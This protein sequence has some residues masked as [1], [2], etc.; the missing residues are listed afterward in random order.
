MDKTPAIS[1][2]RTDLCGVRQ[3]WDEIRMRSLAKR[4]G[5]NLRKTITFSALS[6]DRISR[7]LDQIER[8][9]A[10]AVFVPHLDHLEGE[11]NRVIA[12]ADVVVDVDEVYVRWSPIGAVL[13]DPEQVDG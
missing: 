8:E 10:E 1:Y 3:R 12:V 4:L 11:H 13:D 6:D 5:Y 2:L 9:Q 7:L